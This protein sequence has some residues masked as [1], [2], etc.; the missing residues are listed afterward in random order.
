MLLRHKH[1]GTGAQS[2]WEG[3][4]SVPRDGGAAAV[5]PWMTKDMGHGAT[6]SA[7]TRS[8]LKPTQPSPTPPLL[9]L[10]RLCAYAKEQEASEKGISSVAEAK[11]RTTK[12]T[13]APLT[14]RIKRPVD[15]I[16]PGDLKAARDPGWI[17]ERPFSPLSHPRRTFSP[18]HFLSFIKTPLD[19]FA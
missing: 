10:F 17:G 4:S 6:G 8:T 9:I 11:H 5:P 1:T 15:R 7:D 3:D 16:R 18:L 14:A 12:E 2:E 13:R 19:T